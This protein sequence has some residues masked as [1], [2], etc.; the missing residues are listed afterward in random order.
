MIDE[1]NKCCVTNLEKVEITTNFELGN[2]LR[3][4]WIKMDGWMLDTF[5][6][7]IISKGVES[8]SSML[9]CES[10]KVHQEKGGGGSVKV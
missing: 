6:V 8:I 1:W 2:I 3:G 5:Q 9:K 10:K 7:G 4:S